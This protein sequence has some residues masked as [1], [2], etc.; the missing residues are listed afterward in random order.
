MSD[1]NGIITQF[2]LD[3]EVNFIS[4]TI[5]INASIKE[6]SLVNNVIQSYNISFEHLLYT[7]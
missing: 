6:F 5:L 1:H 2:F 4:L 3:P 7:R